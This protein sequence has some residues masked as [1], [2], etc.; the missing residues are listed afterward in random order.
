MMTD[1]FVRRPEL[2]L[3]HGAWHGPWCW[4]ELIPELNRNGWTTHTVTLPSTLSDGATPPKCTPGLYDDAAA[5]EKALTAIDVPVAVIA[6]SYGGA[7]A[8]EAAARAA[9]VSYLIY[10]AAFQLDTGESVRSSMGA[11]PNLPMPTCQY[12]PALSSETLYHD[13]EPAVAARAANRLR[14]QSDLSRAQC[15][16]HAGWHTLPSSYVVCD[17][18][19][20]IPPARQM[21]FAARADTVH[22]IDT[23]HSPFYAAPRELA[24]LIER[25]LLAPRSKRAW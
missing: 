6:H 25:I 17:R 21:Q 16:Q 19:R 13:V 23:G 5:I 11:D 7:P 3:V 20:A 18:D 22:H 8:T 15:I 4:E 14:D 10:L 12:A 2:L 24:T 9:N 1:R